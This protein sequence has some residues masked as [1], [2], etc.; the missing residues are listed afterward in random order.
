MCGSS[1][2]ATAVKKCAQTAKYE[3]A[4]RGTI[5][6]F[7]IEFVSEAQSTFSEGV[8]GNVNW[9]RIHETEP[10]I[11]SVPLHCSWGPS[12]LAS[13]LHGRHLES[14]ASACVLL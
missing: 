12:T 11:S 4:K 13:S 7:A 14:V 2:I 3:L 5:H 6:K 10:L 8:D 9:I 1:G